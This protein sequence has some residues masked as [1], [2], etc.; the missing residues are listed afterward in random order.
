MLWLFKEWLR[1]KKTTNNIT[2][3][4]SFGGWMTELGPK[5][6]SQLVPPVHGLPLVVSPVPKLMLSGKKS[7][8]LCSDSVGNYAGD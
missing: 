3:S 7:P 1:Y 2:A 5:L 6:R 8:V 4:R